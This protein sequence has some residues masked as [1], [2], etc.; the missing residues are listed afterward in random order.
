MPSY[1]EASVQ[2]RRIWCGLLNARQAWPKVRFVDYQ[3]NAS[4]PLD[5][6]NYSGVYSLEDIQP[7]GAAEKW[8]SS[9]PLRRRCTRR[10]AAAGDSA[11]TDR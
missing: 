10:A 5:A 2:G 8:E 1:G 9:K 7:L 4:P 11:A 6:K 3:I